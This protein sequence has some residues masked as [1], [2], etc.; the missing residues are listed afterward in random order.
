MFGNDDQFDNVATDSGAERE[1]A[2]NAGEDSPDAD[3]ILTPYDTWLP[4]PHFKGVRGPHPDSCDGDLLSQEE[5]DAL[6]AA[7]DALVA[8]GIVPDDVTMAAALDDDDSVC[9]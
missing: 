9:F 3:W 1:Y 4:N 8:K 7:Y 2:S 6:D 5:C